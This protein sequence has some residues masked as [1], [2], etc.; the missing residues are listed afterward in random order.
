MQKQKQADGHQQSI[1]SINRSPEQSPSHH[2]P[3]ANFD[4]PEYRYIKKQNTVGRDDSKI[5]AKMHRED[6]FN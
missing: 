6:T 2:K 3:S 1:V 4:E 5:P